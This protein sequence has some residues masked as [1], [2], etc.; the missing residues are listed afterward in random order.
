MKEHFANERELHFELYRHLRNWIEGVYGEANYSK[1]SVK[2]EISK[3]PE[4]D[5]VPPPMGKRYVS[6]DLAIFYDDT[7]YLTMES[8]MK[9]QVVNA[10]RM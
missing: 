3:N 7:L 8:N 5:D 10:Q 1:I 6:T 4:I 9:K 2:P